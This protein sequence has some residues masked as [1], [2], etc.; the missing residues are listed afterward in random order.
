MRTMAEHV[1]IITEYWQS[2][3][4][5]YNCSD[6]QQVAEGIVQYAQMIQRLKPGRKVILSVG[7]IANRFREE[8][9]TVIKAFVSLQEK[10]KA[11]PVS[12][13]KL[14]KVRA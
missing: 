11:D 10:G 3:F 6:T 7:Q 1:Q 8:P 14:W 5:H 12:S 2:K 9:R 4:S 13:R